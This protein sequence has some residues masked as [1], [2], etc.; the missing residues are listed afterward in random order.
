[1]AVIS[2]NAFDFCPKMETIFVEPGSKLSLRVV[3][4]LRSRWTLTI[5]PR[6]ALEEPGQ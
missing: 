5:A 1:M 4:Y 3:A 6:P 2:K